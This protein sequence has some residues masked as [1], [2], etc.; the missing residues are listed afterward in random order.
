MDIESSYSS[1]ILQYAA[2]RNDDIIIP[3]E[4]ITRD[5]IACGDAI[6]IQGEKDNDVIRFEITVVDGCLLT[7]AMSSYLCTRG[8]GKNFHLIGRWCSFIR[9]RIT[10]NPQV[11]FDFWGILY[12]PDRL[13]CF[14]A[15]LDLLID[16]QNKLA[17]RRPVAYKMKNTE[18]D[19]D[20][21]A[22]VR[23]STI[24]W[25]G[26][27]QEVVRLQDDDEIVVSDEYRKKWYEVSKLYLSKP[28]IDLLRNLVSTM[29]EDDMIFLRHEKIAQCVFSNLVNYGLSD[30]SRQPIWKIIY[31]QIHRKKI[32]RREIDLLSDFLRTVDASFIKGVNTSSLYEK[33]H[34]VRIHLD[35]DILCFS[36]KAAWEVGCYLLNRGFLIF[37][38][39]FSLKVVSDSGRDTLQ[40]HFHAQKILDDQFKIVVDIN[41]PGF[42]VG[43]IGIFYPEYQGIFL[44]YEEQFVITL[45][46]TFKH[47]FVF[48]KDLNDL[49]LMVKQCRLDTGKISSLIRNSSLEYFASVALRYIFENYDLNDAEKECCKKMIP[50]EYVM[51]PDPIIAEW[52]YTE[53]SML[54]VKQRD[55]LSR[56]ERQKDNP[57]I[58]LLP[59]LL[60]KNPLSDECRKK[61]LGCFSSCKPISET[62]LSCP[63]NNARILVSGIGCFLDKETSDGRTID[64]NSLRNCLKGILSAAGMDKDQ[65]LSIPIA[66]KTDKWFY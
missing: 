12:L 33:F 22:C 41:F 59:L 28:E 34:A 24:S 27:N 46:H 2:A 29:T 63:F 40:G 17:A 38:D 13:Q 60:F 53:R 30:F 47:R 35:Y 5:G 25:S 43:R 57:R 9:S 1:K 11:I 20:C 54:A 6:V 66:P 26:Q 51:A 58:Y 31:Y 45:C 49:Y 32:V 15:P 36:E 14:T 4:I 16:L 23:S 64:R 62:I 50:A 10:R 8:S 39:V 21:D 19:L 7:R 65:L 55:L 48:M 37:K 18:L 61:I 44:T 52:P 56:K 42:P 3:D